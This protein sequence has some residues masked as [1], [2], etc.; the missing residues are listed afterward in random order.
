MGDAGKVFV[1]KID[2]NTHKCTYEKKSMPDPGRAA[3]V[4]SPG[5]VIQKPQPCVSINPSIS[6]YTRKQ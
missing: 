4:I 5:R 6:K 3:I 1:I 2:E